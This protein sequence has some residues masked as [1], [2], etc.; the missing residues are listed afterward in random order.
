MNIK[1][2]AHNFNPILGFSYGYSKDAL[3]TSVSKKKRQNNSFYENIIS[4]NYD[5]MEKEKENE[6]K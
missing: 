2:S 6:K 3:R 5:D 4:G 1:E